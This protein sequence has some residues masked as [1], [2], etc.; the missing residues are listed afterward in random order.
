MNSLILAVA[1]TN[2]IA[3]NV[4]HQGDI[5]TITPQVTVTQPCEC[6]VNIQ[7]LREG[8]GG[9]ST[10]QQ[11][12]TLKLPANQPI[13]LSRMQLNIS[14]NDTVRVVVTL[15]DGQSLNLSAQWP[16]EGRT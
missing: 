7:T 11:S 3:F 5:Y 15:S 4:T 6:R 1:L 2:S 14:Q 12:K 13:D 8:S 10:I 9:T 16:T